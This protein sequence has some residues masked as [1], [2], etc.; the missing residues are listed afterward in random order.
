M[1]DELKMN[2]WKIELKKKWSTKQ[3]LSTWKISSEQSKIVSS[4]IF[5]VTDQQ[6]FSLLF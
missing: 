2:E 6:T 4:G 3:I 5:Q 1:Y